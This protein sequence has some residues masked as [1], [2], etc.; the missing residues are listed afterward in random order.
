MEHN[1]NAQLEITNYSNPFINTFSIDVFQNII[2]LFRDKANKT[3]LTASEHI[4]YNKVRNLPASRGFTAITNKVKLTN[5][6]DPQYG[7]KSAQSGLNYQL[8]YNFKTLVESFKLPIDS[9]D[10]F[11]NN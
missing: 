6:Y 8:N 9:Q 3:G 11:L 7:F 1:M 5:G 10:Y 2:Q 4:L